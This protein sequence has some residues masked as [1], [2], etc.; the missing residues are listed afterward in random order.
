MFLTGSSTRLLLF[1]NSKRNDKLI[2]PKTNTYSEYF[3]TPMSFRSMG[4]DNIENAKIMDRVEIP[5][6]ILSSLKSATFRKLACW[7]ELGANSTVVGL[8][9]VRLL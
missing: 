5:G 1:P 9:S 8:I 2:N 4:T 3:V 7:K 6:K